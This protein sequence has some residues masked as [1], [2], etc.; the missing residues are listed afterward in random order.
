MTIVTRMYRERAF[1][2][3]SLTLSSRDFCRRIDHLHV[4]RSAREFES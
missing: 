4:R 1:L 2:S 3:V